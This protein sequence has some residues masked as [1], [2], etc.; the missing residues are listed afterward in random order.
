MV[1]LA[2]MLTILLGIAAALL[3]GADAASASSA[4]HSPRVSRRR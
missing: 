1:I 2:L 3:T 4:S